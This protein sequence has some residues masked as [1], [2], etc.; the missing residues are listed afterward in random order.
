MKY[1]SIN[2]REFETNGEKSVW[3][4]NNSPVTMK[5]AGE[6][7]TLYS[8][9]VYYP[10]EYGEKERL[11]V[12]ATFIPI[13]LSQYT[14]K[15]NFINSNSFRTQVIKMNLLIL[16]EQEANRVIKEL[17]SSYEKEKLRLSQSDFLKNKQQ[18]ENRPDSQIENYVKTI[19]GIGEDNIANYDEAKVLNTLRMNEESFTQEHWKLFVDLSNDDS[20]K[21]FALSKLN[22]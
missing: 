17:G 12:P 2:L 7:G 22:R 14:A 10:N 15:K 1:N 6:P 21:E 4:V 9:V 18:E 3:V 8:I 5:D 16:N 13:D 11:E 19:L 20:V